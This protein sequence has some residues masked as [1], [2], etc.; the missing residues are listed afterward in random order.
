MNAPARPESRFRRWSSRVD[1]AVLML[2]IGPLMICFAW[3]VTLGQITKD[4]NRALV[5]GYRE[6]NGMSR[7][8]AEQ[9]QHRLDDF[10]Q[11]V[12]VVRAAYVAADK[13]TGAPHID[14]PTLLHDAGYPRQQQVPV[15]IVDT[16]LRTVVGEVQGDSGW[17]AKVLSSTRTRLDGPA[18]STPMLAHGEQPDTLA[19]SRPLRHPDGA[20]AAAVIATV[21]PDQIL[22]NLRKLNVGPMVRQF[23]TVDLGRDDIA[24][25][26]GMDGRVRAVL[27]GGAPLP[28]ER[29]PTG[30]VIYRL[31]DGSIQQVS[32][33]VVDAVPRLWSG[34]YLR[35]FQLIIVVGISRKEALRTFQWHR[36]I[37][38]M[39]STAF[40]LGVGV[41]TILA[42]VLA[43]RQKR[44]L[45]RLADTER[46]ANELKSSFLAKISHDLRTP[47]N[48]ILGF[49]ELVKTT[50]SEA[51]QRQYGEYIHDSSSH[52]LDLVN[53]I[54]DL[55]KLR[56]GTLQ[57]QL[58]EVDLRQVAM[59]ISRMH[60][61]VAKDK[62]LEYRLEIADDFPAHVRCDPVRIREVMDNL[63]HNAVKFTRVGHV[64]MELSL[65]GERVTVRVSDTGIGMTETVKQHLF[66]PFNEGR[67]AVSQ[68]M[69]GA[70]LGLAFSRELITMHGGAIDVE[71][72]QDAGIAVTFWIPLRG[73][74]ATGRSAAANVETNEGNSHASRTDSR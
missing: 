26:L 22:S 70:G 21:R 48:G 28:A 9:T 68:P 35:D 24:A 45:Q 13:E 55:A 17:L 50:A 2:L 54:L 8:F 46:Q 61:L 20:F 6:A 31:K 42:A 40:T 59:S 71:S 32:Q 10:D 37:Y 58:S 65:Q 60:A 69:A 73:P 38:L 25:I 3:I 11:M 19:V 43:R 44:T 14:V 18:V 29:W 49:S 27:L 72:L 5:E 57:L 39:G 56:N 15:G 23:G 41:L 16:S 7:S 52:L 53:M 47:L 36:Q 12:R 67:D 62:G 64:A 63:L 30:P 66:R 1:P 51:D 33:P 4:R 74:A 34:G